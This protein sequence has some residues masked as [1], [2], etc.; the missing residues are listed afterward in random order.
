MARWGKPFVLLSGMAVMMVATA[1]APLVPGFVPVVACVVVAGFLTMALFPAVMGSVPDIV[2]RRQV[3]AA[4]GLLNL[5][6]LLGT[7]F[8][9]WI[10]GVLLDS[11]GRGPQDGGY[12]AGYLWLAL[13]PLLGTVTAAVYLVTR[14]RPP[15]GPRR[16]ARV[17]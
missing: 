8:A 5:T 17:K 4:S 16:T 3:G 11:Y 13:F 15:S 10:F 9:P 14:N 1:L 12:L 2:Q 7:L 6:N